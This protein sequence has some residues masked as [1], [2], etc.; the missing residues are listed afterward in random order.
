MVKVAELMSTEVV[1]VS[2][3]TPIYAAM[4]LLVESDVT[5]LPVVDNNMHPVGVVSEKDVLGVLLQSNGD[6]STVGDIMTPG[7]VTFDIE[8]NSEALCETLINNSF[9]RLPV[10]SEGK[11]V[12]IVTRRDVI[13]HLLQSRNE[14]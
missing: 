1:T 9:R 3:D 11:L 10:V 14:H 12:G 4:R 6:T 5:G 13:R 8:G 2:G 7:V